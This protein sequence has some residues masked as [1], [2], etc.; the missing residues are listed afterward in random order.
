MRPTRVRG[1]LSGV[2]ENKKRILSV[3]RPVRMG[4][5]RPLRAG[6]APILTGRTTDRIRFL[7]SFTPLSDPLTLVGL[8]LE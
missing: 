8:T 2:K 7:F 3:V 1:S 6:T 5:L 4:G